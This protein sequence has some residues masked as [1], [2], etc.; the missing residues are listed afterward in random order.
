VDVSQIK[1][2]KDNEGCYYCQPCWLEKD[3]KRSPGLVKTPTEVAKD[4]LA[5]LGDKGVLKNQR[6][7]GK[8][9]APEGSVECPSC[10]EL[11][12]AKAKKCRFCGH[13]LSQDEYDLV[14]APLGG[15]APASSLDA[16][17]ELSRQTAPNPGGAGPHSLIRCPACHGMFSLNNMRNNR[18]SLICGECYSS[19]KRPG[20]RPVRESKSGIGRV[21]IYVAL[22][23]LVIGGLAATKI[24]YQRLYLN[25]KK[26]AQ[27][28]ATEKQYIDHLDKS[29]EKWTKVAAEEQPKEKAPFPAKELRSA[30]E[31]DYP[32]TRG[33][34][35]IKA[36][37][38]K[39]GDELDFPY[40]IEITVS[41]T[42]RVLV[43]SEPDQAVYTFHCDDDFKLS[44]NYTIRGGE[45][46]S[47]INELTKAVQ[48]GL[49]HVRSSR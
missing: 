23:V 15:T 32:G 39:K 25:Q 16:L 4:S 3:S 35:V 9:D 43:D 5:A 48:R 17:T 2:I 29:K 1:R 19:G 20:V 37:S 6:V 42:Y 10:A 44:D 11:I 12:K 28:T 47:E 14:P 38:I 7:G 40:A 21:L 41:S 49:T 18:G 36:I 22:A 26:D 30:I 8:G 13:V 46:Y 33:N 27:A 45:R 34:F 24:V 31:K